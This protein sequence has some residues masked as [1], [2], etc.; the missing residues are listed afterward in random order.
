MTRIFFRNA[1]ESADS[2]VNSDNPLPVDVG[3]LAVNNANSNGE[4]ASLV[5]KA[6]TGRLY[7]LVVYNNSANQQFIQLHDATS[8][9][10][11][12]ATPIVVF[13]VPTQ[14]ARTLDF[15]IRGRRFNKGIIVCNSSTDTTKTIGSADC[16]F[17]AQFL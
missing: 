4:R 9:P 3:T 17:D 5:V 6:E 15:G 8:V 14:T 16:V 11:D 1:G 12:G 2:Q 13:E 7:G 10:A